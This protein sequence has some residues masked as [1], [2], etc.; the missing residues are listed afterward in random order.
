MD[1]FRGNRQTFSP[2]VA[3]RTT[4]IKSSVKMCLLPSVVVEQEIR[5]RKAISREIR[6]H[7][8][9]FRTFAGILPLTGA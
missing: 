1:A 8:Y 7:L 3:E 9:R 6:A 2:S 5:R 4:R